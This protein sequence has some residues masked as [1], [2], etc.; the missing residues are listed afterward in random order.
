MAN[1]SF[2][3]DR[4]KGPPPRLREDIPETAWR[5]L[6]A[7]IESRIERNWLAQEFPSWCPDGNGI[8]E[9]NHRNLA[10]TLVALVP[11]LRWPLDRNEVPDTESVLDML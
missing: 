2:Y 8:S 5:G 7:L 9:T 1:R 10:D 11:D 6:A 3:T 4:T